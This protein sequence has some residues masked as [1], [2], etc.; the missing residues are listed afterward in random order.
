MSYRQKINAARKLLWSA[1]PLFGA[2][3]LIAPTLYGLYSGTVYESLEDCSG[4]CAKSLAGPVRK[5]LMH[6]GEPLEPPPVSPAR[7]LPTNWGE[8]VQADDDVEI[9]QTSPEE[10]PAIDIHSL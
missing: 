4:E 7:G 2:V 3:A 10:L 9:V 1:G 5:I 6:L 8:F